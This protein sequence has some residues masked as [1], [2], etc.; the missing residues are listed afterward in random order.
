MISIINPPEQ[1]DM[2][3]KT[4]LWKMSYT[5][6]QLQHIFLWYLDWEQEKRLRQRIKDKYLENKVIL[7]ISL[8]TFPFL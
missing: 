4:L 5:Q 6:T 1:Q 8:D 2:R 3:D 7:E